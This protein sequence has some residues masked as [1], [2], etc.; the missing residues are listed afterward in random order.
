MPH[1]NL[2]DYDV[3]VESDPTE[4]WFKLTL[5]E[6]D[7]EGRIYDVM[8]MGDRQPTLK[9]IAGF[10]DISEGRCRN[11]NPKFLRVKDWWD[12]FNR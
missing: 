5:A 2:D 11:D 7:V 4:E 1:I 3:Q 12:T 9:E 10:F 8:S 6:N